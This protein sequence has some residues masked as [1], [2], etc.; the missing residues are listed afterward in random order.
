MAS[1]HVHVQAELSARYRRAPQQIRPRPRAGPTTARLVGRLLWRRR[2]HRQSPPFSPRGSADR[3]LEE[4]VMRNDRAHPVERPASRSG[5][6]CSS[7]SS[8]VLSK[9][10][11]PSGSISSARVAEAPQVRRAITICA[12]SCP[13]MSLP[14]SGEAPGRTRSCGD[15]RRLAISSCGHVPRSSSI[16]ICAP[17]CR[18]RQARHETYL[19]PLSRSGWRTRTRGRFEQATIFAEPRSTRSTQKG[20]LPHAAAF[21]AGPL[22]AARERRRRRDVLADISLDVPPRDSSSRWPDRRA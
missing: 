8:A 4:P 10:I 12:W 15:S 16:C 9:S 20:P 3:L 2:W 18:Q 13:T 11:T 17:R 19:F 21:P 22:D 5:T 1:W 6:R 14:P 7:R